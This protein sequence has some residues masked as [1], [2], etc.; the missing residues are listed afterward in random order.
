MVDQKFDIVGIG[1]AIVDVIADVEDQYLQDHEQRKGLMSLV[2]LE[3]IKK[4]SDTLNIKTT[5]SGGSV[6]N[7]I[8]CLAQHNKKCAFIGK[9]GE[10]TVGNKFIEGLSK[11]QV[12]FAN[13]PQSDEAETGRCVVMVT[14]DAQ[15]T[16]STYLGISQKLN[17][18]DINEEVIKNSGITYLE[19]YLW[20]LD[21]AQVAIKKATECA[22]KNGKKV[23]FS[24]SDV[25]CI[26]RFRDSFKGIIENDAD[27][28]FANEEE[29]KAL[30]EV[31]DLNSAIEKMKNINK[32]FAI[33][34]GENGAQIITS[35]DS[36][37]IQPEKI[38]QL[39]DTTGAGDIFA[40]G[41]L[42]EY[43]NNKSLLYCG[44]KGVNLASQIIQKYGARL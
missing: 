6:A 33:T 32:I 1:N 3:G 10:D 17:S 30:F 8:V 41:F 18:D 25:F 9:V 13:S 28:I 5:V 35:T 37:I 20:D 31:N 27:I 15:R 26:E 2:D 7:S 23:A 34:R 39:V 36:I 42:L 40:A 21:D 19:G 4:I 24:V 16:M 43:I 38:E 11:E 44:N 14:P 22:K 29:A 12:H